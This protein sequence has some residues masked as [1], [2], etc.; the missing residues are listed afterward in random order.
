MHRQNMKQYRNNTQAGIN[1]RYG[2]CNF[3]E[4]KRASDSCAILD[5]SKTSWLSEPVICGSSPS[6][7]DTLRHRQASTRGEQSDGGE[8][9]AQSGECSGGVYSCFTCR[10][11]QTIDPASSRGRRFV[12]I[13]AISDRQSFFPALPNVAQKCLMYPIHLNPRVLGG[14]RGVQHSNITTR[15]YCQ[16]QL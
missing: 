4:F 8:D 15:T 9:D 7:I 14:E 6:P 10:R 16:G 13:K 2:V 3:Q 1:K 11:Y 12:P 5:N